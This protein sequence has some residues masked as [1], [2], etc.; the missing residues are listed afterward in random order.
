MAGETTGSTKATRDARLSKGKTITTIETQAILAAEL[1]A[2]D[3]TLY[4]NIRI[5]S[6][7]IIT[8]ISLYN[9][10]L[11]SNGSPTLTIDCGLAAGEDFTS[12]TSSTDTNHSED[13][14]LDADAYVDGSTAGQAA[15]TSWTSQAFDS[16]TFGP[17]D[18]EKACWEVLG[19]D[20][21]PKTTF[22]LSL[23][24]AAAAATAAAGDLAVKVTYSVD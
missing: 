9:D 14:V 11:D 13:D 17:D 7:A 15:T 22:V 1:E 8:D 23:T 6:N 2:A 24:F 20:N 10:D 19:Y 21:D 16:A 18:C 3:V 12:T 5:P 4:R